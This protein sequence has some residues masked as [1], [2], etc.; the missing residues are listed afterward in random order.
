M[1]V[2]AKALVDEVASTKQGKSASERRCAILEAT[3]LTCRFAERTGVSR[4]DWGNQSRGLVVQYFRAGNSPS[5]FGGPAPVMERARRS[6]GTGVLPFVL[7][8]CLFTGACQRPVSM[9]TSSTAPEAAVRAE[10]KPI[11]PL[12][13]PEP[14]TPASAYDGW[15]LRGLDAKVLL[16]RAKQAARAGNDRA[17]VVYQYWGVA[18]TGVEQ[19][20]L[21]CYLAR[22]GDVEA[23]L[24]WLQVAGLEDGVYAEWADTDSDLR[25]LRGDARW[26]AV[27]KYL[28]QCASYWAV[29]GNALTILVLPKGYDGKTPIAALF[30]LN[31]S[32]SG[33][34]FRNDARSADLEAAADRLNVAVVGVSGTVPL[35]K[36][37]FNWSEEPERDFQRVHDAMV[38]VG[39]RVRIKPG[40]AILIGFSQGGQ[41]GLEVAARHPER[42]AGAIAV[43]PGSRRGSLLDRAAGSTLLKSRAF[44]LAVGGADSAPRRRLASED[45]AWLRR[46]GAKVAENTY[47]QAGHVIPPDFAR[48]LPE[49]VRL[50][51]DAPGQ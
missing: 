20:D 29:H 51:A 32:N 30:W 27:R 15:D 47:P 4:A 9:E 35:G 50:V 25:A 28:R 17:A 33:P 6:Q 40:A 39:S 24:Y 5:L 31:G 48:R 3:E 38:E 43:A 13:L 45:A 23:A 26:L 46:A 49:W 2:K 44:V 21:A 10:A 8:L 37:K 12:T 18:K 11:P 14:A 42:F 16:S 1:S 19:Y 41:V 34:D 36:A 22:L 7:A